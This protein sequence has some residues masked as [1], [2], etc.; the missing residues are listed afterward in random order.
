MPLKNILMKTLIKSILVNNIA[1]KHKKLLSK[2]EV[3]NLLIKVLNILQVI[4]Q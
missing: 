3:S 2:T 1:Y 4:G